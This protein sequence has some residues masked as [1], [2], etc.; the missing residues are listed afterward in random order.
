MMTQ[1]HTSM[2]GERPADVLAKSCEPSES[3]ATSDFIVLDH[4]FTELLNHRVLRLKSLNERGSFV[5][6]DYW[7]STPGWYW[8]FS[9]PVGRAWWRWTSPSLDAE[10]RAI[11]DAAM[12]KGQWVNCDYSEWEAL[13]AEEAAQVDGKTR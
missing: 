6:E 4:Y 11:G 9:T 8:M 10:T 1:F 3:L 5:S 7:K 13:I 2:L 12:S